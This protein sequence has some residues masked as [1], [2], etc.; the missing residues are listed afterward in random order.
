MDIKETIN[1]M[2][3]LLGMEVFDKVEE[4][5]TEE[6]I[7]EEVKTEEVKTEDFVETPEP[8]AEEIE[9]E[10]EVDLEKR[11]ADLEAQLSELMNVINTMFEK[12]TEKQEEFSKKLEKI[13][14]EELAQPATFSKQKELKFEEMTEFQKFMF[15]RKNNK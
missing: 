12:Q 14:N 5:K 9:E 1:E 13:E 4:V 15:L 2:K 8:V 6:V 11:V 7:T 10:T 3:R